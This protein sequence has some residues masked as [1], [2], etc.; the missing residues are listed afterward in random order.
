MIKEWQ[1]MGRKTNG[2][3]PAQPSNEGLGNK[4]QIRY[5]CIGGGRPMRGEHHKSVRC[6]SNPR[7]NEKTALEL[8]K[9]RNERQRWQRVN[10]HEWS[11]RKE[12]QRGSLGKTKPLWK[13]AKRSSATQCGV[14]AVAPFH[15]TAVWMETSSKAL[16]SVPLGDSFPTY[17]SKHY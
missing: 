17:K 6:S 13:E 1:Q 3:R 9:G 14:F 5:F 12:T 2:R 16:T 10:G 4:K 8:E 15:L 11:N 7:N